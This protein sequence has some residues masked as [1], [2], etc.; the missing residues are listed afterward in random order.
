[1]EEEGRETQGDLLLTESVGFCHLPISVPSSL[2]FLAQNFSKMCTE[3][4]VIIP[5]ICDI[6]LGRH[7]SCDL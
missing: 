1:M 7:L 6:E 4:E 2:I 5:I 3:G